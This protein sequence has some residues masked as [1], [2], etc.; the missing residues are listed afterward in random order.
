MNIRKISE[1]AS[2]MTLAWDPVP[3]AAA[4]YRGRD[5]TVSKWTQTQD[6]KMTFAK[7]ASVVIQALGVED[8]GTWPQATP[9][10]PPPP[11]YTYRFATYNSDTDKIWGV[12]NR[13]QGSP[14]WWVPGTPGGTPW[15]SGGGIFPVTH[16]TYGPGFQFITTDEM[17][18][19]AGSGINCRNA[20]DPSIFG[21][22][23]RLERPVYGSTHTWEGTFMRP[24]GYSWPAGEQHES[25]WE[26]FATHAGFDAVYHH[27]FLSN[28][29][30]APGFKYYLGLQ[31]LAPTESPPQ[32]N[33]WDRH[34]CPIPFNEDEH[35]TIRWQIK[36]SSPGVAN[37]FVKA[38]TSVEGGPF[39]QWLD[40]P[41]FVTKLSSFQ[42]CYGLAQTGLRAPLGGGPISFFA[43][44]LGV[45]IS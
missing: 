20:V 6:T 28:G 42:R 16:G 17:L 14:H 15:P 25:L 2:K 31:K 39:Q 26:M 19:V 45:T 11:A 12:L 7:G 40:L 41:N 3:G 30:W 24:S 34:V 27:L 36:W 33:L 44:N 22:D 10:P 21:G 13:F 35:H 23:T 4:G 37:G 29:A 38:W 1:T 32:S 43:Y 8:E 9:P 5:V 18:Y